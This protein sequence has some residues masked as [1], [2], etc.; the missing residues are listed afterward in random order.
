MRKANIVWAKQK[1]WQ[2]NSHRWQ[3]VCNSRIKSSN[4]FL[5]RGFNFLLEAK[6]EYGL[7]T[8][9]VQQKLGFRH[10]DGYSSYVLPPLLGQTKSLFRGPRW[11]S[12]KPVVFPGTPLARSLWTPLFYSLVLWTDWILC[13]AFEPLSSCFLLS[14]LAFQPHAAWE[15]ANAFTIP[16]LFGAFAPQVLVALVDLNSIFCLPNLV[17]LLQVPA[18]TFCSASG[19]LTLNWKTPWRKKKKK[20][21]NIGLPTQWVLL[22]SRILVPQILAVWM[23]SLCCFVTVFVVLLL[24]MCPACR[25]VIN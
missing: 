5:W 11:L 20:A 8:S 24:S 7:I 4:F 12:W 9:L 13:L 1:L 19:H 23:P 22:L 21:V 25:I 10:C 15:V 16:F 3:S 2:V 17:R 6:R 18:T 14:F